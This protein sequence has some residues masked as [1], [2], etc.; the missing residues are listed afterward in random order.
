[1]CMFFQGF[2]FPQNV[3]NKQMSLP[4]LW[5]RFDIRHRKTLKASTDRISSEVW[6]KQASSKPLFPAFKD[7]QR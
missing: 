1:M 4:N 3:T 2:F 5:S 7:V 6:N